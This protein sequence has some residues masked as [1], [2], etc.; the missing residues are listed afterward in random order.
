MGVQSSRSTTPLIS[1]FSAFST[2]R[3]NTRV[4]ILRQTR[5]PSSPV[6]SLQQ[7]STV[8]VQGR[9][10]RKQVNI[11]WFFSRSTLPSSCNQ[12]LN[13]LLN[14]SLCL[15]L[16][17]KIHDCIILSGHFCPSGHH[18]ILQKLVPGLNLCSLKTC[19]CSLN[20][21]LP[22]YPI[23]EGP[24][25]IEI[26]CKKGVLFLNGPQRVKGFQQ[27]QGH[28]NHRDSMSTQR[29]K[30]FLHLFTSLCR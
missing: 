4:Y 13:Y 19:C 20:R 24:Q 23:S 28:I 10:V 29:N 9:N 11:E 30:A 5:A 18:I 2:A 17:L 14:W 15:G 26:V 16:F 7:E 6:L 25:Y 22:F 27:N 1:G 8:H 3:V 12:Q 21:S